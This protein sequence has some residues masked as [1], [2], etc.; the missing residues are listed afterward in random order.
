MAKGR[1]CMRVCGCTGEGGEGGGHDLV[2]TG[3]Q[4]DGTKEAKETRCREDGQGYKGV[5]GG[6]LRTTS[7]EPYQV[8]KQC[9]QQIRPNPSDA[10]GHAER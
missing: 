9:E 7:P 6:L 1:V 8:R 4:K 3:G 5:E 2:C 10:G